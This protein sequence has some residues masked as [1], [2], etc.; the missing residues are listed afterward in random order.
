MGVDLRD[1]DQ[2]ESSLGVGQQPGPTTV[3]GTVYI[4]DVVRAQLTPEGVEELVKTTAARDGPNVEILLE[5]EPGSAGK[6]VTD[7]FKRTHLRGYYVTVER[8][9]GPKHIRANLFY[10]AAERGDVVLLRARWN[11][12]LLGELEDFP[13][14]DHD[15]QVD[16]CAYAYNRLCGPRP[17]G[18][19]WRG[20]RDLNRTHPATAGE[21]ITGA[22]WGSRS[23]TLRLH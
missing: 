13:G 12:D 9:T 6:I 11:K 16:T 5:Q 2:R 8:P 10:A 17:L 4:G 1:K 23:T 15:D 18:P 3:G 14:G 19:S 21:V 22:T 20:P 7:Q